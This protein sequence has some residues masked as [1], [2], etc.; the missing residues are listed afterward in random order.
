M[1]DIN[2]IW[3]EDFPSRLARELTRIDDESLMRAF[4]RDVM[5]KKEILEIG[6]RLRA[7]EMLRAGSTYAQIEAETKLS[8]RTIARI[9]DWLQKGAGGYNAVLDHAHLKPAPAD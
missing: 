4:L 3:K 7:A 8:S 9:S 2:D 5:T 6:A 1:K